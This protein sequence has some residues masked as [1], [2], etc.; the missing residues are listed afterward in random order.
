[1]YTHAYTQADTQTHTYCNQSKCIIGRRNSDNAAW[2]SGM[3]RS[4]R[5]QIFS[6]TI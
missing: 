4:K 2:H 5:N 1:M 6:P 3:Q